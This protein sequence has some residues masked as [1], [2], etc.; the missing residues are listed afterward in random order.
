VITKLSEYLIVSPKTK[1]EF[2]Q[3]F[4]LRWKVLRQPWG[5]PPGSEKSDDDATS[6]HRMAVDKDGQPI[7]VGRLHFN[8][9]SE[10]QIRY[11]GVADQYRGTGQGSRLI[12]DLENISFRNNRLE[13]I[14]QAREIAVPFYESNGY[15]V[16]KKTHIIFGTIQHYLMKK[17]LTSLNN[18]Q[19]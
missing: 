14:L 12:N 5:Q 9:D 2:E 6:F 16:V 19:R 13:I 17:T 4:H 8:S 1:R 11:M 3:Y 18:P 10:A 15:R 7:A